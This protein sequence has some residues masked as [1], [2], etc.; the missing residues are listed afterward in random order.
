MGKERARPWAFPAGALLY[1]YDP[2]LP[3]GQNA[4]P[5]RIGLQER[6]SNCLLYTSVILII[7]VF[8]GISMVQ[9]TGYD[10][11]ALPL[12]LII[13]VSLAKSFSYES[14]RT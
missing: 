3:Q 4:L 7:V 14:W 10:V 13:I 6:V 5:Y 12:T 11:L 9:A 1:E 2:T 8:G